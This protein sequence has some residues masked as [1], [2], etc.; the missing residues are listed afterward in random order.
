MG[1]RDL[2]A[3]RRGVQRSPL[4]TL[5]SYSRSNVQMCYGIARLRP[6]NSS[7]QADTKGLLIE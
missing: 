5:C 7:Y 3:S 2:W 4:L 6:G 1:L